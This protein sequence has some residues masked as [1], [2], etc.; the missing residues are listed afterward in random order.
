MEWRLGWRDRRLEEAGPPRG[1]AA[2]LSVNNAFITYA[3]PSQKN[4]E[5]RNI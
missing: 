4:V 2:W 3:P 1:D 5:I